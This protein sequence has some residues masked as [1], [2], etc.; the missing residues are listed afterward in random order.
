MLELAAER[1][2]GAHTYL[3]PPEHTRLARDVLGPTALLVP[4]QAVVLDENP[5]QARRL[6]R[7]HIRRY[8]PLHNYTR[9]LCHLGFSEADFV[10]DGSDRLVDAI[11]AHG[12]VAR[13]KE[14]IRAH[15]E[16]GATHV[17]LHILSPTYQQFPIAQWR[18]LLR[19]Q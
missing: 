1:A 11:V 10:G 7:T 18:A 5:S 2:D 12:S 14:R 19:P 3:V 8:L 4:E 6:A 16:A 17:C 9:N 13:I 15:R